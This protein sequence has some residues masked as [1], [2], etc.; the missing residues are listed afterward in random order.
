ME[1]KVLPL[2]LSLCL[3]SFGQLYAQQTITGKVTSAEEGEPLIGVNIL[4]QGTAT[5]TVTDFDGNFTITAKPDETLQFSYTGYEEVQIQVGNRTNLN[6]LMESASELLGEVIVVGYGAVKKSDLTGSVAS[7]KSED[8]LDAAPTSIQQALQGRV[9][10]VQVVS[11]DGAPG[12]GVSIKIRGGNTLTG[13]NQPLYVIDGFP[14]FPG[15]DADFNPLGDL[16]PSDIESIESLKDASATSVYGAEGSNGVIMVTTK[17]GQAGK[18]KLSINA[19]TGL[20]ELPSQ[21]ETLTGEQFVGRMRDR[22]IEDGTDPGDSNWDEWYEERIWEEPGAY[23][24]W[25]DHISRTAR[26]YNVDASISGGDKNGTLYAFSVGYNTE[27]GVINRS[28]Y[29]RLTTRLNLDQKV[30]D[31]LTLGT[32][33]S[34]S[35]RNYGGMINDWTVQNALL[36][37]VY[38]NPFIPIDDPLGEAL[39]EGF[40][41][42]WTAQNPITYIEDIDFGK[43]FNRFIGNMYANYE[44]T[45]DLTFRTSIGGNLE[46]RDIH[47]FYPS[48]TRT[49]QATSGRINFWQ[50]KN[51]NWVYEA[52]LNYNKRFGQHRINLTGVSETK[53]YSFRSERTDATQIA[54]S[55]SLGLYAISSTTLPQ[56]QTLNLEEYTVQSFLGRINYN[57]K[58]RY[59]LTA[60]Y[61]VDG[62]SKF[63][64]G[65]KWGYFPAAA[66]AWRVSEEPFM[67]GNGVVDNL[68]FRASFGVTGNNQIPQYQSLALL[69][70]EVFSF[71]EQVAIGKSPNRVENSDLKWETTT[72]YNAGFDV[73][74]F[75]NRLTLVADAYYKK[76]EDLLLLVELPTSSGFQTAIQNVG[77]I[78]N[79]GLEFALSTVN[80]DGKFKWFT[81]FNISFNRSKVLDLGEN[82]ELRLSS[83]IQNVADDILVRVGEPIGVYYGFIQ[84]GVYNSATE[85]NN[86]GNITVANRDPGETKFVD[87]NGDGVI[88]NDDQVPLGYTLPNHIG[89]ITNTF[90]YGGFD[91]NVFLR[92]SVG[93]DVVN[94][95]LRYTTMTRTGNNLLAS[96][97]DGWWSEVNPERNYHKQSAI[98]H[99][100]YFRSEYIEDGSFLRVENISLG[101]NLP[102]P[103]LDKMGVST[104]RIY[105]SVNNLRNFTR[106]SFYDPEVNS[107]TGTAA[108]VGPGLDKGVYPRS[109]IFRFGLTTN[110]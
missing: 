101:Y 13:G 106:Y 44:I 8:F 66:F 34:Y 48:T 108:K 32:G 91:L 41:V 33:M 9:A 42:N 97:A 2:L 47:K 21:I 100:N 51:Y 26:S 71:G 52:R 65:N 103:M 95:N 18:P 80:F 31:R 98:K 88:N 89:G 81:D 29:N 54:S 43:S 27:E 12:G 75:N 73:G 36:Q 25:M 110:F 53:K 68:K 46:F 83:S 14:I 19:F 49:G 105:A 35:L 7:I 86:A 45:P 76:T 99:E 72:Q 77:S 61:R 6:V 59:L 11:N 40:N 78:E 63:G 64:T 58:E 15:D 84:D 22:I 70:E 57:F 4:I 50:N 109:R 96:L 79:K 10:G 28:E 107:G 93:N 69:Q 82:N 5:G 56:A 23:T 60:S 39:D 1:R 38:I 87:V 37:A 30:S 102:G 62:S 85:V 16:N 74:F 3:L 94:G 17:R 67:K 90:S 104:F 55:E 92:W 24:N 20:S